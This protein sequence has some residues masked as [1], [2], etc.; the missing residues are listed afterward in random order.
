MVALNTK[1]LILTIK[2][3]CLYHFQFLL[4]DANKY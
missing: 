3:Q 1:I 2:L 4:D